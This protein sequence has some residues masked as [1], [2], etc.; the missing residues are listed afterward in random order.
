MTLTKTT[1]ILLAGACALTLSACHFTHG[2]RGSGVRATEARHVEAFHAVRISGSAE[3]DIEV[4]AATNLTITGDDNLLP[5]VRTRVQDGELRVSM[6]SG[7]YDWR[8]GLVVNI[9][10]PDLNGVTI[11][12]SGDITVHEAAGEYLSLEINGSGDVRATGSVDKLEA[13]VSG[14]GDFKLAGLQVRDASVAIRGSGDAHLS[15]LE[16]L[17]IDI[18]GSGDVRYHGDPVVRSSIRGSGDV[19]RLD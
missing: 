11:S 7:S 2:I 13:F 4:G 12:G 16:S 5:Y 6:K 19:R 15:A 17:E 1:P 18:S 14:S 3:V 9:G 10:T 8:E